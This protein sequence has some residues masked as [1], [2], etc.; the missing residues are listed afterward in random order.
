MSDMENGTFKVQQLRDFPHY[1]SAEENAALK[2]WG[3]QAEGLTNGAT[4]P[5]SAR[6]AKFVEVI[7]G[8]SAPVTRFQRLWL[9]YLQ[10]VL[11]QEKL[12]SSEQ[13]LT[14]VTRRLDS[15]NSRIEKLQEDVLRLTKLWKFARDSV[16]IPKI[17]PVNSQKSLNQSPSPH[18]NC[19]TTQ[20]KA[21]PETFKPIFVQDV[22]N[23][24][25]YLQFTEKGLVSLSDN[26]I[27]MLF[28]LVDA[29][30]LTPQE[31]A[32]FNIEHIHR[33]GKYQSTGG[34]GV[35]DWDWRDQNEAK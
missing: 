34:V 27:F 28:N 29:L 12:R 5:T 19:G 26:E 15:A 31:V 7:G 22:T 11:I 24:D 13:S 21:L 4:L 33:A 35:T 2:R 14:T 1:L 10:A 32:D 3:A 17:D 6:E 23:R 25:Q 16:D 8:K 20:V 9:R 18:Q 30:A